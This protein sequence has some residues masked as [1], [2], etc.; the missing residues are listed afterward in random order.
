LKHILSINQEPGQ[1][2]WWWDS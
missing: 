2:T 1:S